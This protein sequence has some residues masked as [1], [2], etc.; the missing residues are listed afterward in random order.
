MHKRSNEPVF[1]ALFGAGGVLAA[2]FAPVLIFLSGLAIPLGLL[3]AEFMS[4]E[5]ALALVSSLPGAIALLLVISLF[6]WHAMHRI[7]HSL[8]DFGIRA[9]LAGKVIFYGFALLGTGLCAYI[10]ALQF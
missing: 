9:G 3:P 1:W 8:H 7:N 4:Y 5:R 2:L 6:L 10:L